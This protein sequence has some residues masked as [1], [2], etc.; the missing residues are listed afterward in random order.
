MVPVCWIAESIDGW[1]DQRT[2]SLKAFGCLR[3]E[4]GWVD[5]TRNGRK[6]DPIALPESLQ[7]INGQRES[8]VP[9]MA[10]GGGFPSD[11]Q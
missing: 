10:T 3:L 5:Q 4:V 6:A 1:K 11:A 2:G 8:G 7:F 9:E